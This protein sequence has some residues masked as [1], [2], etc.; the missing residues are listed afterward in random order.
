MQG[1]GQEAFSF[2]R[3]GRWQKDAALEA[4]TARTAEAVENSRTR[5]Y[6]ALL[7]EYGPETTLEGL[8]EFETLFWKKRHERHGDY[9]RT[10]ILGTIPSR[11]RAFTGTTIVAIDFERGTT[12]REYLWTPEGKIGDLGPLSSAPSS[13]YFPESADCFVR[14]EPAEAVVSSRICLEKDARHGRAATVVQ[15]ERRVELKKL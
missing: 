2:V 5:K 4:L 13:R 3:N 15:G 7:K 1:E 10:R 9:V 14:F 8:A 11:S 12:Y 6:E